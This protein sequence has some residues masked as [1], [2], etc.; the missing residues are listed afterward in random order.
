MR[1]PGW[2]LGLVALGLLTGCVSVKI[3]REF[4]SPDAHWIVNGRSDRWGL[5]RMLGEPYQV[6][7]ENGDPTWRWLYV[8]R[9]GASA[10]SKDLIVRFSSDG[11]VRSYSFT[12][13]FPDDLR[14]LK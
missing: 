2:L 12:S 3:G 6:G 7:F 1:A 4:P 11:L 10:V 8:E 5:Q 13:N 9:L 14:R